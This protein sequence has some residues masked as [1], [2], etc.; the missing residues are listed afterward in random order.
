[1]GANLAIPP[2]SLISSIPN[3]GRR[4]AEDTV[5]PTLNRTLAIAAPGVPA[6]RNRLMK[7]GSSQAAGRRVSRV[8]RPANSLHSHNVSAMKTAVPATAPLLRC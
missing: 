7:R 1:M 6:T 2:D 5:D 3:E 8:K 4:P